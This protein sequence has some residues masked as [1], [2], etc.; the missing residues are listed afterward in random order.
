M[1]VS[2]E[3]QER[4]KF[5][6]GP[7][8]LL[9]I[10]VRGQDYHGRDNQENQFK[11][12]RVRIDNNMPKKTVTGVLNCGIELLRD[13]KAQRHNQSEQRHRYRDDATFDEQVNHHDHQGQKVRLISGA[14]K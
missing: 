14:S 6:I 9:D 7:D 12:E 3:K 5:A 4:V 10:A 13:H 1:P 8:I 11:E 2:G